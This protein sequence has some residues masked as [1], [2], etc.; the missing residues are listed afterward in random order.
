MAGERRA[1]ES[2]AE[3]YARERDVARL[4][5]Q[6]RTVFKIERKVIRVLTTADVEILVGLIA[7]A[8]V[9]LESGVLTDDIRGHR[10]ENITDVRH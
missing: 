8:Q 1:P 10:G 9:M 2:G 4:Q 5:L 7:N 3:Q 6:A